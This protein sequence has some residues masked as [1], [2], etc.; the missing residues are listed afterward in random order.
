VCTVCTVLLLP[1]LGQLAS[2]LAV[3]PVPF[4]HDW[5]ECR[6]S[7]WVQHSIDLIECTRHSLTLCVVLAPH[8]LPQAMAP[9]QSL[10]ETL[11]R[12]AWA[13]T[14]A[15]HLIEQ[16]D[17]L[18]LFYLIFLE[19]FEKHPTEER[20]RRLYDFFF[21]NHG[22]TISIEV[23]EEVVLSIERQL[24]QPPVNLAVLQKFFEKP[25]DEAAD[26]V[27]EHL[28]EFAA[29]VA[30]PAR[31]AATGAAKLISLLDDDESGAMVTEKVR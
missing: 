1:L 24:N 20:A 2:Q 4:R 12:P 13:A 18:D 30:D 10:A 5:R 17:G 3:Y 25:R 29:L 28:A 7:L 22:V 9:F 19:Q 6:R 11:A 26:I 21:A 8:P 15:H 14:F 23:D 16:G 31:S 27:G